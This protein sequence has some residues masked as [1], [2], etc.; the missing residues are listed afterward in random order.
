MCDD[1][2]RVETLWGRSGYWGWVLSTSHCCRLGIVMLQN[3]TQTLNWDAAVATRSIAA[4]EMRGEGTLPC[5]RT[6]WCSEEVSREEWLMEGAFIVMLQGLR[7]AIM[8]NTGNSGFVRQLFHRVDPWET[9]FWLRRGQ[10]PPL[11]HQEG[12]I[13]GE[14]IRTPVIV[15]AGDEYDVIMVML[16]Q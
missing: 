14:S 10:A 12:S 8:N 3:L 2:K 9:L 1:T 5:R 7:G 15:V 13:T 6:F 11:C 16:S 4:W